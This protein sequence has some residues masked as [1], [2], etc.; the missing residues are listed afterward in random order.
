MYIYIY[1]YISFVYRYIDWKSKP[2]MFKH[3]EH[4][5]HPEHVFWFDHLEHE[6]ASERRQPER[7]AFENRGGQELS[8]LMIIA[9][10]NLCQERHEFN[11]SMNQ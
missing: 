10:T 3:L 4:V 6:R 11:K 5:R 7:S 1:I 8:K 9:I 2:D